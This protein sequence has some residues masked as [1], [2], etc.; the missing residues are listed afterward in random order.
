[1]WDLRVA[2]CYK[3][4][5][6]TKKC[7]ADCASVAP[8][9]HYFV[10]FGK[11]ADI[12]MTFQLCMFTKFGVIHRAAM[13]IFYLYENIEERD[14]GKNRA[15]KKIQ[16]Q[17]ALGTRSFQILL[18]LGSLLFLWLSWQTTFPIP[19]QQENLIYAGQFNGT[20]FSSCVKRS[21]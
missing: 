2:N 7:I 18:A 8:G 16:F 14:I 21:I 1:M 10:K 17:L 4:P 11:F 5:I 12:F 20:F 15:R 9:I 13:L 3:L 19:C 6:A